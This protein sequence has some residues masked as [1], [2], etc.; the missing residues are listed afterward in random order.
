MT[1]ALL[2]LL[3]IVFIGAT[4]YLAWEVAKTQEEAKR[5]YA[6]KLEAEKRASDYLSDKGAIVAE[7]SH[8]KGFRELAERRCETIEKDASR[9]TLEMKALRARLESMIAVDPEIERKA[10][11]HVAECARIRAEKEKEETARARER[12]L[13]A[14]GQ[15][16]VSKLLQE[17]KRG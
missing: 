17:M 13:L 7:L 10:N 6:D 4:G 14:E 8:S 5:L 1:E 15:A 3:L 16:R 12:A 9:L 2:S 11:K